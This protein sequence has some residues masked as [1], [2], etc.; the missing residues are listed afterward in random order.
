M[1]KAATPN[2]LFRSDTLLGVC[3]GI[4]E[5]FGFNPVWLRVGFALALLANFEIAIAA[6]LGAGVLVALSRLIYRQPGRVASVPKLVAQQA[7]SAP[8]AVQDDAVEP[9]AMAA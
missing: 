5:D 7:K 2:L 8:A 9:A 6:Y 3:Q 1:T 4:G